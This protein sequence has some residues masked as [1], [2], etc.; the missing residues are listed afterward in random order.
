VTAVKRS[1]KRGKAS[2]PTAR[3][4]SRINAVS[5]ILLKDALALIADAYQNSELA[6]RK[7]CKAFVESQVRT[8]AACAEGGWISE[9]G[10]KQW[11]E[12]EHN[13]RL[14]DLW[15][16]EY[17]RPDGEPRSGKLQLLWQ[18]SSAAVLTGHPGPVTFFRIE[19]AKE[20]LKK[21]LPKGY[22]LPQQQ[23]APAPQRKRGGGRPE[24]YEWDRVFAQ[25]MRLVEED[26]WPEIQSY[27][28]FAEKVCDACAKAEME[29]TPSVDTVREK[30][31]VWN[32]ARRR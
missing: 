10:Q 29:P 31:S 26:G 9:P 27:R 7:L 28:E 17:V 25:F 18:D 1:I 32:S 3:A 22:N 30:I 14:S 13:L 4:A 15:R 6:Q 11:K 21:L 19:V 16:P 12:Y 24:Q 23:P 5:W 2:K 20:D 8:R